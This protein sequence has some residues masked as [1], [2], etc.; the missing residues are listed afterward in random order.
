MQYIDLGYISADQC[1]EFLAMGSV[2]QYFR[3]KLE[4]ELQRIDGYINKYG[5]YRDYDQVDV[6]Q[7]R[8]AKNM[9]ETK[10]AV[11]KELDIKLRNV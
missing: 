1:E 8:Q 2:E 5:P 3:N 11:L 4:D 6:E 9:I 7:L 10:L